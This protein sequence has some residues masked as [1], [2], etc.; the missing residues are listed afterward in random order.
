MGKLEDDFAG[1]GGQ[2]SST[3]IARL[4]QKAAQMVLSPERQG[5]RHHARAGE[6][7]AKYGDS[8]FGQGCLLARR[9]VE[10]GVTFVEVLE[11]RLGHAR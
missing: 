5:L 9:L 11:P 8:D 6:L 10:T 4:Y 1:R 2:P 3:T 7:S